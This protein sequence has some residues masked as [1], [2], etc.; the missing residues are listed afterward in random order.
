MSNDR[1][2]DAS[3]PERNQ[4]RSDADIEDCTEWWSTWK[5]TISVRER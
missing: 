2:G 5:S 4:P 1:I 3:G